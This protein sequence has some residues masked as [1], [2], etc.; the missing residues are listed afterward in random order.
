MVATASA[1][2]IA[3]AVAVVAVEAGV[4]FASSIPFQSRG[5]AA[6]QWRQVV[7][8]RAVLHPVRVPLGLRDRRG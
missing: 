2:E 5:S 4:P 1:R 6:C 3:G 8:R 7:A